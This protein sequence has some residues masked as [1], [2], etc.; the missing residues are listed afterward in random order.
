[1]EEYTGTGYDFMELTSNF[2]R[3]SKII[4]T[5]V[6]LASFHIESINPDN[7]NK[8]KQFRIEINILITKLLIIATIIGTMHLVLN[9]TSLC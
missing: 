2:T 5:L 4:G 1:M 7:L 8:V 6:K 3:K 9:R